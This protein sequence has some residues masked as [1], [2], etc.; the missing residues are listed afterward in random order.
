M[1]FLIKAHLRMVQTDFVLYKGFCSQTIN[2]VQVKYLLK[3]GLH[4]FIGSLHIVFSLRC[5]EYKKTDFNLS[6]MCIKQALLPQNLFMNNMFL[7][8]LN[9]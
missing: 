8:D 6:K 5:Q 4:V 2:A 1:R 3:F 9:P 7:I